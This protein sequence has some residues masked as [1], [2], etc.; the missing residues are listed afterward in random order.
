M[1]LGNSKSK[2]SLVLY[3]NAILVVYQDTCFSVCD[4]NKKNHNTQIIGMLSFL[5][6]KNDLVDLPSS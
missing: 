4:E 5:H 3:Q 1:P 6:N 2:F